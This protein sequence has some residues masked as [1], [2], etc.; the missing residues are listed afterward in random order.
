MACTTP[1]DGQNTVVVISYAHGLDVVAT[2]FFGQTLPAITNGTT[3]S[4][5]DQNRI[6]RYLNK[7]YLEPE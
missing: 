1:F 7:L 5:N 4:Y 2:A 6:E 3:I